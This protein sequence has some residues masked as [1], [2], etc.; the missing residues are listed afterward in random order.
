M[1]DTIH[2]PD[3]P[4]IAGLAFRP[5]RGL[6]DAAALYAIHQTRR[7]HDEVDP[8]STLESVPTLEQVRTILS[9]AVAAGHPDRWLL[10]QVD[11]TVVGYNRVLSWQEMDGMW[12]YLSLGWV[13]P[14]WRGRGIGTALLHWSE[15][16]SRHLAAVEHPGEPAEHAANASGTEREATALLLHEGYYVAYTAL[17]MA[18][19]P[20][21][22]IPELPLP[23]GFEV[24]PPRPEHYPLIAACVDAAYRNEFRAGR[25]AEKFDPAGYIA[26]LGTPRHD[27][28]LW[29]VA[30]AGEQVAGLVI[31]LVERG[32]GEIYEVGVHPSF[33]RRGL[34]RALLCR[35]LRGLRERGIDT[36]RLH[37]NDDFPTRAKD[38]YRSVGFR[39][40]KE[41]PRY[42]KPFGSS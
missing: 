7:I 10:A 28:T 14:E 32:R 34:A 38:L 36:I 8:L 41:F 29:Q 3:A 24:R 12:V 6:E 22:A 25:F 23:A 40:A 30:W 4:A 31:P 42:R 19:D 9:D 5:L 18:F 21:V 11:E 2:L 27:P 37:T 13:L 35:A 15:G 33:R 1:T 20:A 17:E 16:L 39:L 26:E